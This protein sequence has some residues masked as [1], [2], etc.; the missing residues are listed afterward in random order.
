MVRE[1]AAPAADDVFADL[2]RR[3][4]EGRKSAEA[5]EGRASFRDKRKPDW[6]P[7]QP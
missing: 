3:G 1:V 4:A 6:Y 7:G 5:T 2:E